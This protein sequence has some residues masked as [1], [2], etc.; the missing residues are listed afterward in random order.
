MLK[1]EA[2][3]KAKLKAA[4]ELFPELLPQNET[5]LEIDEEKYP[6]DFDIIKLMDEAEDP[7]TGLIR[8][9]RIDDRDL[10]A[11]R[12]YWD[13][14]YNIIGKDANPPWL[15]QMWIGVM[16]FAECCPRCSDKR[17]F[18]LSYIV[19]HVNKGMSSELLPEHLKL[20]KNGKCPKCKCHKHELIA[21]YGLRNYQ[22]LVNVLGQRSGKSSSA[23]SYSSYLGHRWLKFPK[24]ASMTK[25]MQKSTELTGTFVSLTFSKAEALLWTPFIN[26]INES[27]WY[28]NYHELLDF[29]GNKYGIELYRKKD[30]FIKYYHKNFK[31]YPTH[32]N[33]SIL[34]GDTRV[35]P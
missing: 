27:T 6:D 7:D 23:A 17:W 2:R 32:P 22:E 4:M 24:L 20:L 19:D 10:P 25:A 34:R 9:L 14:C 15:I 8:D 11:A 12:N 33:G 35:F 30:I 16:L 18:D 28:Q 21:E 26:I 3:K 1:G 31:F 13:Y 29:Y 5:P